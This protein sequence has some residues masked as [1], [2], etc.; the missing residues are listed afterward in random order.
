[1]RPGVSL[2]W[3]GFEAAAGDLDMQRDEQALLALGQRRKKK[4]ANKFG[5]TAVTP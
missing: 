4:A 3:P 5:E 2:S 1:M